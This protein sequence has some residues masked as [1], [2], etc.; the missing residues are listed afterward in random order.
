MEWV[1]LR[2]INLGDLKLPPDIKLADSDFGKS[3][4][5]DVLFGVEFFCEIL[6]TL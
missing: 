1:P 2:K 4:N 3:A 5:I 6:E